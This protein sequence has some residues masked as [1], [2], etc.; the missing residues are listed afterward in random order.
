MG[1][2]VDFNTLTEIAKCRC[3]C[4]KV[5]N[6]KCLASEINMFCGGIYF[7]NFLYDPVCII[8]KMTVSAINKAV[9][10]LICSFDLILYVIST[11]FQ[12]NRDGSSWVEPVLS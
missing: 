12:L 6:K 3:F 10:L 9:H 5:F 2:G 1:G 4:T 8:R 7:S 11:I